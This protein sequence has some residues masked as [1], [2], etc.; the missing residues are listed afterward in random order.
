MDDIPITR[1]LFKSG[2]STVL[3]IP[4]EILDKAGFEKGDSVA[5]SITGSGEIRLK[6]ASDIQD[7]AEAPAGD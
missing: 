2:N 1:E 3:T 5:F 4:P 6:R 7:E